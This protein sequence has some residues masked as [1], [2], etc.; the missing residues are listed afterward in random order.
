YVPVWATTAAGEQAAFERLVDLLL[1]TFREHPDLHIYHFGA[2]E[3]SAF[4][5]LSGRYATRETELDVLLRAEL[6][7]DL[8]T[9][10]KHSLK[11]S[12]ETYSIKELEKFYGFSRQQDMRE[13]TASRRAIEWAIEFKEPV[14]GVAEFAPHIDAVE[15]YNR[16]DCVSAEKLRLWLESLR[17]EVEGRGISLSRPAPESG[18]ASEQVEETADET[19]EVMNRLLAGVSPEVEERN[20]VQHACWLLAHL[21]EWHRREEKAAWW[22]YFRLRDLPL[23]EYV[24][25]RS[26]LAGLT[27]VATVGGTAKRPIHRYAFPAQD[28]DIRRNDEVCIP[29]GS[30]IGTVDDLDLG[31]RTVD[32]QHSG[33][34]ADE[35]PAHVFVR[36]NV[37]PGSKPAA[38]FALGR[39]VAEHGI[40][41]PG[42]YRAARDLI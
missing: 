6:F 36:R 9:I 30:S 40:D 23:D 18:D 41:A 5:R 22:E 28:H 31:G 20:E 7:V 33:K 12:V 15:R 4:K 1:A 25:E 19:R 34:W 8:H 32:L 29:D 27:F 17:A 24:D 42:A 39:W 14:S 35:R 21:L 16:E 37:P 38:L 11:A 3:P 10:V 13:A 26:A 2:Y